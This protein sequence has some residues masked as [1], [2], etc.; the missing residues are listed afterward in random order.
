MSSLRTFRLFRPL[1]SLT[2]MPSMRILVGTLLQS[3]V[4]LGG[5]MALAL[6]FFMIYAILGVTTWNGKIHYRCYETPWPITDNKGGLIWN[7]HA[8]DNRLCDPDVCPPI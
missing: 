7:V 6:F 1:R 2:T 8:T 3:V 4:S 5:I